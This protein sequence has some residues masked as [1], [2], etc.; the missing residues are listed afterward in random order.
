MVRCCAI[1]C[2][3]ADSAQAASPGEPSGSGSSRSIC[4]S[5]ARPRREQESSEWGKGSDRVGLLDEKSKEEELAEVEEAKAWRQELFDA[6][7]GWIT[8]PPEYG[9]R[10]LTSAHERGYREL[11]AGH[12]ERDAEH[13]SKRVGDRA[14]GGLGR[15]W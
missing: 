5:P 9:G 14:R 4:G 1:A 6:G 2:S 10:G 13:S 12:G 15:G 11:G 7:F 3:P 8:G